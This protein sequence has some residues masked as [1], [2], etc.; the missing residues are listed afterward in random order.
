MRLQ[1]Y[2]RVNWRFKN[3]INYECLGKINNILS[4]KK[5]LNLYIACM[6][7]EF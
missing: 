7:G 4:R 5:E 6:K 2:K 1:L 3:Y